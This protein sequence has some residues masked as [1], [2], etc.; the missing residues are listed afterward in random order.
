MTTKTLTK[1][2]NRFLAL[3]LTIAALVAG[4]SNVWGTTKTVTYTLSREKVG[5]YNFFALTHSGD[6]PFDG[7]TT[8]EHQQE[9]NATQ[10]TFH[11]PDGFTFTFN[12]GSGATITSVGSG[13]STSYFYCG[14]ANVRFQLH[15][16]IPHRYVTNVKV[17]DDQGN[18]S[19]LN[20]SGTATTDYNYAEQGSASYILKNY[21]N[22]VR[23][24]ITYSD[25]PGLS[26]FQSAGTNTYNIGTKHDLRHLAD[27]VNNGGNDCS[28]LTFLQTKA[29]TCDN[30]YTPIGYVSYTDRAMFRGTYDGGGFTISGITVNRTGNTAADGHVGLFGYIGEG[31]TVK[32]VV[33]ASSTFTGR[34]AVGGIVGKNNS[35]TVENCSVES[36]V[37]INAGYNDA[38][39]LGGIVGDNL[40][41]KVIGCISAAVVSSNGKDNCKYYG[42][43][44]G[45]ND[46]RATVKNCLYTGS[47]VEAASYKGAIVGKDYSNDGIFSN[48]YYTNIDLGGVN[49]SDQNG[50]R[51]ARIVTLGENIALVGDET[52]YNYS[53]ITA[54]G[55]TALRYNNTLYSGATQTLT[56]SYTGEVPDGYSMVFAASAGTISGNEL[57]MPAADVAVS[58]NVYKTD[59]ITHWQAGPA[60]DGSSAAKAYIITTPAGLQLLASE[61][62][63]GNNFSGTY[64]KLDGDLDMSG[65]AAFDPIGQYNSKP[66][67]GH[68][69]GQSHT[70][71]GLTVNIDAYNY[72]GLFGRVDGSVSHLTLSGASI[73]GISS[74]GGIAGC[75]FSDNSS[76]TDCHVVSSIITSTD[77]EGSFGAIVGIINFGTVSGCTYHSTIVRASNDTRGYFHTDGDAFNIGIGYYW[78]QSPAYGD[79]SGACLDATQLF[80]SDDCDNSA[81]IAAYA[82][83]ASHTAYSGTAPYFSS[84]INVTLRGR[85]LTKNGDWNTLCLPFDVTSILEGAT[86]KELD[87]T[88][89]NLTNGTLTLNFKDE[90]TKLLAGKPYI[91][92]W[93]SGDNLVNPTFSGVTVTSTTPTAVNF[94]GGSFVGQYSPF[95]IGDT[96]TGTFDGNL[97]EV[98]LLSTG[99]RLGYSKNA[100]TLHTFR[101]HFEIPTTTGAP[102]M[103][104]FVLNFDGET[105]SLTPIPSPTG[106][107]SEY[108]YTLD[109][110]KLDKQ[111]TNPGLYI[112]NGKKV[113]IK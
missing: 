62:N 90:T 101:C 94:S 59:Y 45:E 97:N 72:I 38:L 63:G 112:N 17:T 64:F 12:W 76:L 58:A 41:G 99:N 80:L 28:G 37:T 51:R 74:V 69:D 24:V 95:T 7:T 67:C 109:G 88:T 23:L 4:Q 52:I 77:K 35:G 5:D 11:L 36:S 103:N 44:V 96:S 31:G 110:R 98:I 86:V 20:G 18:P 106:E 29:I 83:P 56:L 81:L 91:I 43:I 13:G 92:K 82:A 27:Y 84:G 78:N 65:V 10:A 19:S 89:S 6:T 54:I 85:T 70:I 102:A 49:G 93:T 8:V 42:G 39:Y 40:Y 104:S 75:L 60:H 53:G 3:V 48:N 30:T 105:T 46:Y 113:V 111:P 47:N 22:F 1:R 73:T 50:A 66:F 34:D 71:S 68:F 16:D 61:T 25:A 33:L 57:T 87:A 108:W 107:G 2:I 26:L 55:I 14:N 32:N 79:F 21:A 9:T 15:W 100:R